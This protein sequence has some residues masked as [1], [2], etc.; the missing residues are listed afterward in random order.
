MQITGVSLEDFQAIVE[1]VS[2]E[3]YQGNLIV[4]P[5][6]RDL[7]GKRAPRIQ[8]RVTVK[9][10]G[11]REGLPVS[12]TLPGVRRSS[13]NFSVNAEGYARRVHAAC[14]HAYRDVLT[15]LFERYPDAR[16]STAFAKYNGKAGFLAEY[17]DTAYR[18]IGSMVYPVY[19]SDACDCN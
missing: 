3:Q 17:P 9:S 15:E 10:I 5:D 4:H 7:H 18:N 14:W 16:V 8:G 19:A 13:S 11:Y 6:S 12:E 2:A 1:K